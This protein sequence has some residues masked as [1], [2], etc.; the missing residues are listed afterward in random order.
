M[1]WTE[2]RDAAVSA[3][4]RGW[5]VVPGT[6]RPDERGFPELGPLQDTWDLAPVTDPERAEEVWTRLRRVGVL[7]VCGRGIDALGVPFRVR[8][9]LPALGKRGLTVP[10]ATALAPSRWQLLVATG[11]STLRPDL[12]AASVC[13]RGIGQ[14]AALP[15]TTLGGYPPLQW[16]A[17]LPDDR[18]VRL[19]GADE[20]QRTLAE[21]LNS[22]RPDDGR[23]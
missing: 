4:R 13:L 23:G 19:P 15:P 5:P 7:L 10:V 9:L 6:C 22:G 1:T 3:V 20:V 16:T 18:A 11:S 21:A 12:A 8:E 14:W 2:V 17:T